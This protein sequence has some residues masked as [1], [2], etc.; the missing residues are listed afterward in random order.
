MKFLSL[1]FH[2]SN[3][4]PSIF[5]LRDKYSTRT[6]KDKDTEKIKTHNLKQGDVQAQIEPTSTVG[7]NGSHTTHTHTLGAIK[8]KIAEDLLEI[9][10]GEETLQ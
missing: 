6:T 5:C 7:D 3:L 9:S 8:Q 1:Q 10:D 2:Q 4:I